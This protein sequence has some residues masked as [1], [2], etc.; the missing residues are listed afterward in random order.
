MSSTFRITSNAIVCL[1]AKT[2]ELKDWGWTVSDPSSSSELC[3]YDGF[4][5]LKKPFDA[6]KL[7]TKSSANGGSNICYD[8]MHG[9]D[10]GTLTEQMY[11]VNGRE[12]TVG[13]FVSP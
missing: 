7:D 2:A 12:Y 13:L 4:W 6:L 11:N 5:H 10:T 3:D 1:T 9:D 8:V